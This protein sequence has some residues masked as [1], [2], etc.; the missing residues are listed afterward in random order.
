[1]KSKWLIGLLVVSLTINL[2]LIGFGVGRLSSGHFRPPMADPTMGFTR[3]LRELP[4]S[5]RK[6]LAPL[7]HEH[8][9]SM[10]PMVRDIRRGHKAVFQAIAKEPL[11]QDELHQQL[12]KLRT[13]L[14][15][16][17]VANHAAFVQFAAALTPDERRLWR[18]WLQ[19]SHRHDRHRPR[20][21]E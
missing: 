14:D 20:H 9:R 11:N 18:D 3:V 16:S 8:F 7:A 5:R 6:E 10:R 19:R 17:Q 13:A 12:E 2:L 1:M 4:E 15:S 21:R